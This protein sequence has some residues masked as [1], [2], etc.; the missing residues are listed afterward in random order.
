MR[1]G[2]GRTSGRRLAIAGALGLAVLAGWLAY[3]RRPERTLAPAAPIPA[4][5]AASGIESPQDATLPP[6]PASLRDTEVDGALGV[7]SQ[8]RFVPGPAALALFEYF[9]SATGEEP[10][11]T[12]RARIVAHARSV[13]PPAAAAEAEALLDLHLRYREHV[14]ELTTRGEPP[15]DLERR[16]QWIREAR[17]QIFGPDLAAALFAEEEAV[18]AIDLERRRVAKDETLGA[19]ERELR[20]EALEAR[21]PERVRQTRRSASAPAMVA[22]EVDALRES[23]ATEAEI[24]AARERAFGSEAAGRLAALDREQAEFAARVASW[25]SERDAILA[26]P[27]LPAEERQARIE[28]LRDERFSEAERLRVRA[29]EALAERP[30]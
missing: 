1:R 21:L 11:A 3:D 25:R 16:L 4:A 29:L 10:E 14:R 15:E 26:D 18:T 13:L 17:R 19:A 2:V 28:A 24:F 20:L 23:G 8:G 7:D 5:P 12:I 6:L 30:R 22:K 9:F 27:G